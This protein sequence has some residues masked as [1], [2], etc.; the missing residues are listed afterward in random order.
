MQGHYSFPIAAADITY[1]TYFLFEEV[2]PVLEWAQ[3]DLPLF[4]LQ[5]N[6]RELEIG[7]EVIEGLE[8]LLYGQRDH[9]PILH[10][11]AVKVS[12]RM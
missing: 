10:T 2:L 12:E 9:R 8:D 11:Q 3:L 5:L 7:D 6:I 4:V 1:N